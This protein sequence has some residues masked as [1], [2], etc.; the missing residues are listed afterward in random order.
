MKNDVDKRFNDV[1]NIIGFE[2]YILDSQ[3]Y[4]LTS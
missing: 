3:L 1:D 2:N 4:I